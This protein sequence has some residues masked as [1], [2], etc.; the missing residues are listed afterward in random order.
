LQGSQDRLGSRNFL[1]KPYRKQD[2][3][4]RMREVLND[5]ESR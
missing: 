3:A 2:L 1:S 5:P 4:R